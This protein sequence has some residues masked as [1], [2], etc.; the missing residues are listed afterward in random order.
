MATEGEREGDG[1]R[2]KATEGERRRRK[3]REGDGRWEKAP[4]T[5]WK[6]PDGSSRT[7]VIS[8]HSMQSGNEA[9][10]HL[11]EAARRQLEDG[12]LLLRLHPHLHPCHTHAI[13]VRIHVRIHMCIHVRM[14]AHDVHTR[15]GCTFEELHVSH[16]SE[17]LG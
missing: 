8:I 1:G 14:D 12:R 4:L 3:A 2:E 11:L 6:S 5:F 13:H 7:V 15:T 17:L 10:T 16:G 9:C